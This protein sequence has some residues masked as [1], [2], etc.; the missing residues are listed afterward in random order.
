MYNRRFSVADLC[1]VQDPQ[2]TLMRLIRQ[3]AD[4]EDPR[5]LS[6][7]L[8]SRRFLHFEQLA[9]GASKAAALRHAQLDLLQENP[10]PEGESRWQHPFFWAP[11]YLIGDAGGL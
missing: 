2:E 10:Q 1:G 7:R 6:N 3:L 11:F 9:A 8:R 5:S 4:T